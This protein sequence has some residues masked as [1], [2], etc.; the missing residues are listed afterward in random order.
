M[1]RKWVALLMT[2][3]LLVGAGGTYVG[4]NIS[5]TGAE[6]A[7]ENGENSSLLDGPQQSMEEED[8]Q[9]IEYAYELILNQYVEKVE[10]ER[11][12][13]G[14]IHGMLATL[15]DPHSVYMDKKTAQEF[16][17]SLESSFEGIGAEVSMIDG[18][19]IIVAPFKDSPA[20]KAGLK[21]KDQIVAIDGEKIDGLDLY[22]ATLKIRG[23]KGTKVALDILRSGLREPIT[24]EVVRD[25][26]PFE[27]VFSEMINEQNKNIGYMEITSFSEDTA[28]DFKKQLKALEK[29][30]MDGL[31]LDVRENPGGLLSSVEGI[32]RELVTD[33]KPYI[34]TETRDGD[35]RRF[36]STLKKA[37]P[38]PIV[39]LINNGSASASEILAGAL[40][41]IEGYELVGETTFGKGTVQ[42]P[43]EMKDGSSIKLTSL[44]WLTP[45]GNWIHKDGIKPT[46]AIKQ[47]QIFNTHPVQANKTLKLDMNNEQVKNVQEILQS[48]GF[49]PGRTDG[50]F[51]K[52]TVAAVRAFQQQHKLKTTGEIDGQTVVALESEVMK[53]MRERKNDLQLRTAIKILTQKEP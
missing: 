42:Q 37:K 33:K 4:M 26:I 31:V 34:Q 43:I 38:Y 12:I 9:K 29:K 48:L 44:K 15:D 28:T 11:L 46:V 8:I 47:P 6:Q 27:T 51:S 40:N 52:Q 41:E 7:T 16:N 50:Y 10:D 13:E 24:L 35:K 20:E 19:V 39:V 21:S 17:E 49:E 14:A 1:N 23:K 45:N 36:F 32:L 22:E 5:Q 25:E 2:F 53:E 30:K 3:S 18:K